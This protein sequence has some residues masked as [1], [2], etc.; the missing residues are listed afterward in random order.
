MQNLMYQ[1]GKG[2]GLW[3]ACMGLYFLHVYYNSFW[4]FPKAPV[5]ILQFTQDWWGI[6]PRKLLPGSRNMQLFLLNSWI[7]NPCKV[8]LEPKMGYIELKAEG[9]WQKKMKAQEAAFHMHTHMSEVMF[10]KQHMLYGV[11]KCFL[12][13]SKKHVCTVAGVNIEPICC[14]KQPLKAHKNINRQFSKF[15]IQWLGM[16]LMPLEL[17]TLCWAELV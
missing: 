13:V 17:L 6:W 10:C 12:W 4:A 16:V 11:G 5:S 2:K 14:F 3:E 7:V 1:K 15:W 8:A 9:L